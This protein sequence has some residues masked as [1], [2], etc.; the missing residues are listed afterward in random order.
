LQGAKIEE[1]AETNS[2]LMMGS[3]PFLPNI[4]DTILEYDMKWA[5]WRRLMADNFFYL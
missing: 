5:N 1:I 2:P 3:C 4:S